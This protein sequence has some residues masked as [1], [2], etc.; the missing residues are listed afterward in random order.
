MRLCAAGECGET[1]FNSL[2]CVALLVRTLRVH[3]HVL[4]SLLY[5][6]LISAHLF[7]CCSH[8][9][10]DSLHSRA[11]YLHTFNGSLN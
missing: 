2:A 4:V 6:A 5:T 11:Y 10:S 7:F 9:S 8:F 1:G 3:V